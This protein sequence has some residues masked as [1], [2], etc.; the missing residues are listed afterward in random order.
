MTSA[1]Q[2]SLEDEAMKFNGPEYQPEFDLDRLSDQHL[3]IRKAMLNNQWL[4]L[5]E[6]SSLTGDPEA[7]I[8]AQLRHL[9]K[10]RFGGYVVERKPSGDRK[11]GLFKYRV[12]PPG[13]K[14]EFA[15]FDRTR[16]GKCGP[17]C[18]DRCKSLMSSK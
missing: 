13:S 10:D 18:C 17:N 8:S 12:L 4:T 6:I 14:S 5:R 2:S 3:R 9:R 16:S 7:S 11:K 1:N 15:I